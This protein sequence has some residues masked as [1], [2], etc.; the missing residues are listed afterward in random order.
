MTTAYH[1]VLMVVM[2]LI[3]LSAELP[4]N[5]FIRQVSEIR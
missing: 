1:F 4:E 3:V 2:V 5:I